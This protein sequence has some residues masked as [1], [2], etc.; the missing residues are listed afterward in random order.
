MKNTLKE[1]RDFR[2]LYG[3]GRCAKSDCVVVYALRNRYG[4]G[5]LGITVSTKLGHA[6]VRNRMKR[7]IRELYRL[8]AH[9]LRANWDVVVVVRQRATEASYQEIERAFLRCADRSGLRQQGGG[10]PS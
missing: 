4:A 8:H 5:R 6:V 7:I 9:E 10:T 1:N 3:R 2:R